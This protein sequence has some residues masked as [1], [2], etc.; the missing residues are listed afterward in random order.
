MRESLAGNY[1]PALT[2]LDEQ[3]RTR[4]AQAY[5]IKRIRSLETLVKHT[6]HIVGSYFNHWTRCC[7]GFKNKIHK[8]LRA[9]LMRRYLESKQRGFNQWRQGHNWDKIERQRVF[10]YQLTTDERLFVCEVKESK[11]QCQDEN[12]R[13]QR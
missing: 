6:N 12:Q 11:S 2:A 7:D 8:N 5:R 4:A 3:I 9:I 1:V 13:Q 10:N